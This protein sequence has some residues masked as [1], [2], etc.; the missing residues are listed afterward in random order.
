MPLQPWLME[1]SDVTRAGL[2]KGIVPEDIQSG[3]L[4]SLWLKREAVSE[5]DG[6]TTALPMTRHES[7]WGEGGLKA[8]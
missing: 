1:R 8:P 3:C 6:V 5:P 4:K 2:Q 7:L